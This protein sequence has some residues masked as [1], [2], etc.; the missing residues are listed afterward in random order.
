MSAPTTALITNRH[1]EH[2]FGAQIVAPENFP[3]DQ[4]GKRAIFLVGNHSG[5]GLSWDNII[6]DFLVYDR[7]RTAFGDARRAIDTKPVRI[8]DS[9]FLSHKTVAL[10]GIKDWWRRTGCVAATSANIEAAV[11]RRRDMGEAVAYLR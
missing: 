11:R 1:A 9:L 4:V 8:V 3:V 7:L 5:M 2:Y 10:F 6:L